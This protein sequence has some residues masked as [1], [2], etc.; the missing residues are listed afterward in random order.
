M[1]IYGPA[2]KGENSNENFFNINWGYCGK[3]DGYY[4][5][6]VFDMTQREDIDSIIDTNPYT[7]NGTHAYD[8]D[9]EYISY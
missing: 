2:G 1:W 7:L 9:I 6:G 4:H 5:V 8:V 3:Y